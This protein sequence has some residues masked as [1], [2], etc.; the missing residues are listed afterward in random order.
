LSVFLPISG[1]FY[2]QQLDPLVQLRLLQEP[3]SSVAYCNYMIIVLKPNE[4]V[5]IALVAYE[6]ALLG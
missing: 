1:R 2:I 3:E 4:V 5:V 6:Y